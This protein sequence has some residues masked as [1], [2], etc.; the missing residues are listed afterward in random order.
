M[1]NAQKL[2]KQPLPEPNSTLTLRER[3]SAADFLSSLPPQDVEAFLNSL[4][5]NALLSLPWLFEHWAHDHQLA[6]EGDWKTWVIL[7]GRGAGKTRA[8]AEWVR[9]KVEG[10]K[11]H[12]PGQ[13]QRVALVAETL[14]QARDVMVLGESGI[15]ACAPSDR[16][17]VWHASKRMLEWPNG[18]TAQIFSA[19]D[20]E[21]L[22]G[23][24]FDCAWVDE[25]AKW[26]KGEDT[27]DNLQ[28]A[29]RLGDQPQQVVTTTPRDVQLLRDLLDES[30]T[31]QTCA[32]TRVNRAYLADQFVE[33]MEAKYGGTR[34]GRQ[35]LE[36]E[37][38]SAP[39]GALWNAADLAAG[40]MRDPPEMDR[41][42]VALDPPVTSGDKSD[43]C[44][45]IV[46]GV[47][48][49]G[50]PQDWR[51]H[52]IED[53]SV[54]GL[55]PMKWAERAVNLFH[56]HKADRLV[57]EVNQGGEL[58][59]QLL[60]QID[61]LVPFKGVHATRGKVARAEPVA[62]LYEQSRVT[63]AP[64]LTKLEDQMCQVTVGGY[65]GKGS[66]DRVDALVWA[67]TELM[68]DPSEKFRA[69][70]VRTL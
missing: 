65:L 54:Q 12:E 30:G 42:V 66:P 10:G 1:S 22:R 45:I 59:Q 46:A 9:S 17:P 14:D 53:A 64:G 43:A 70:R 57:A 15:I 23:P 34:V 3:R 33:Q 5:H 49:Q 48:T 68:I 69:P 56:K 47:S 31:V 60:R 62:S 51:A 19:S 63:H 35:E 52:V 58:V 29:L 37:L 36:G 32:P 25:L 2:P 39:D 41:I 13:A 11:P 8:G 16:A 21:S 6:P 67:I 20:P 40:I 27:W 61:P 38:L 4:S 24:Q 7:G 44:G 28:F 18:A 50:P 55:S 26:K